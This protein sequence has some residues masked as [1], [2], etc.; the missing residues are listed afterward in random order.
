MVA[1]VGDGAL[2]G[3]MCWEALN[4]IAAAKDRPLVIVVN[5]NA[6]VLRADDRRLRRPPG[7]AADQPGYER[8]LEWGKQTVRSAPV[9]GDTVYGA[10]HGAKKGLKDMI[11]P[12]GLFEDLGLKYVGPVDGHDVEAVETALVAARD[13]GGPVI[14]H[15]ITEK[16]RGY[17]TGGARTSWTGCTRSA[18]RPAP[19]KPAAGRSWTSIFSEEL[20]AVGAERPGRGGDHRVH[21]GPDRAGARSRRAYPD[22]VVRRRAS[23]SSTRSPRP[24]GCPWAGCTRW[25]RST[26]PSSTGP[27]T[28]C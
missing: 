23:P 24:P 13:F 12:Q 3:G 6:P 7:H 11:A 2:T 19:G 4:N 9:V 1:V 18:P 16:G 14:V 10:L 27:S 5:D 17:A 28:R 25:W 15:C 26:R 20:V 21:A 22:R 8:F